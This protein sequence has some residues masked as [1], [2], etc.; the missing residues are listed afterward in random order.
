MEEDCPPPRHR[1]ER[2]LGSVDTFQ[3]AL[4]WPSLASLEGSFDFQQHQ[5]STSLTALKLIQKQYI[6]SNT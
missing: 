1:Q 4:S 6:K 5:C 3:K 2:Q